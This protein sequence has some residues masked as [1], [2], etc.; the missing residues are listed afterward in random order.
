MTAEIIDLPVVR[1]ER[2]EPHLTGQAVCTTCGHEWQ[3]V[4]AAGTVHLDC[5]ACQRM[6]GIFKNA[7]EPQNAWACNCSGNK[8]FFLTRAGAM[9][10]MCGVI[11]SDWANA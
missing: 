6:Q 5:P 11:S 1:I 9:C 8:L 3:A 4:A 10:R 2:D 7:V